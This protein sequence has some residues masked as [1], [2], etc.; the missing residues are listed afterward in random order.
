LTPSVAG[1]RY[2]SFASW[3][4]DTDVGDDGLSEVDFREALNRAGMEVCGGNLTQV[5][6]T[7]VTGGESVGNV[8]WAGRDM[9]LFVVDW[10]DSKIVADGDKGSGHKRWARD[11]SQA[12]APMS[13]PGGY[14]NILTSDA[15]D[16][17]AHAYGENL[18]RL[19]AVKRRF[20]PNDVFSS[21]PLP[22]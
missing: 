22:L 15:Q 20:D 4:G 14:P 9:G 11:L 18:E 12:L 16:Q 5:P 8:A 10:A 21:T 3:F 1:R 7:A 13:L 2:H 17:I 19:Q 6:W